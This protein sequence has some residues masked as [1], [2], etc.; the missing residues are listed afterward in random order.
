VADDRCALCNPGASQPVS[1]CSRHTLAIINSAGP[2]LASPDGPVAKGYRLA[3][4]LYCR[5]PIVHDRRPR[6]GQDGGWRHISTGRQGCE[7]P[8]PDAGGDDT[9]GGRP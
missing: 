7:P 6:R 1:F 8:H 5:L 2:D 3:V 4:C 9:Q